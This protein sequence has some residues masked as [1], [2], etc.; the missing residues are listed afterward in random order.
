MRNLFIYVTATAAFLAGALLLAPAAT[1]ESKDHPSSNTPW[2]IG[3]FIVAAVL[4]GLLFLRLRSGV[5][6][7][8]VTANGR[9]RRP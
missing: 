5:S 6:K 1:A 7:R 8:D 9:F 2:V 4:L 3:A